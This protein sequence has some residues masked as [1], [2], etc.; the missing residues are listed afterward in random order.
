MAKLAWQ[1]PSTTGFRRISSPDPNKPVPYIPTISLNTRI[2]NTYMT[3]DQR[4]AAS[5]RPDVLVYK[6]ERPWIMM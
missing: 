2:L 3:E 6:T 5:R 4:F 1:R